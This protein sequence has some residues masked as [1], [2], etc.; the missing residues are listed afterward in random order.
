ML[1]LTSLCK[2][3]D[4]KSVMLVELDHILYAASSSEENTLTLP[5]SD[6]DA[7]LL[8]MMTKQQAILY[9]ANAGKYSGNGSIDSLVLTKVFEVRAGQA[10]HPKDSE[11]EFKWAAVFDS[12]MKD[13]KYNV[14]NVSWLG[15]TADSKYAASLHKLYL[16]CIQTM[17]LPKH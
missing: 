13:I 12:H 2:D 14:D 4:F 15:W 5:S 10:I 7:L 17:R 9:V 11:S 1:H 16:F 8:H 3:V 6:Y